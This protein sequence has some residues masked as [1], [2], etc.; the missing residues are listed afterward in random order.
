MSQSKGGKL[1][2][3]RRKTQDGSDSARPWFVALALA[4]LAAALAAVVAV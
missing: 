2:P 1:S 3:T 4:T